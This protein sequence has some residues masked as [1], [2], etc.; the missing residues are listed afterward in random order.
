MPFS[1]IML[2]ISTGSS[3]DARRAALHCTAP[4]LEPV[5]NRYLGHNDRR[6]L[7]RVRRDL[8]R[9]RLSIQSTD[10]PLE[11]SPFRSG[12]P[13]ACRYLL[14]GRLSCPASPGFESVLC[15]SPVGLRRMI[16]PLRPFR[17]RNPPSPVTWPNIPQ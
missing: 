2:A 17:R 10:N 9:L 12:I 16:L 7:Q 8:S 13:P 11:R 5:I 4:A 1:L 3:H 6:F 15:G 14:N